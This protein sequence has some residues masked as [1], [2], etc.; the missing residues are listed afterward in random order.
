MTCLAGAPHLR[1]VSLLGEGAQARAYRLKGLEQRYIMGRL[2]E[3]GR[4]PRRR[5]ISEGLSCLERGRCL[6]LERN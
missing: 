4:R 6:E 5:A 3:D 2:Q 1:E